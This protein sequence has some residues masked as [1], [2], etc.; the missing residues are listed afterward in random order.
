AVSY[1]KS[2]KVSAI[3]ITGKA[4]S[5]LAP[6]VPT[7]IES[8]L[9]AF[10]AAVWCGVMAPSRLPKQIAARL[11]TEVNEALKAADVRARLTAGAL[12]IVWCSGPYFADH[13]RAAV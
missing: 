10:D 5:P 7:F 6:D 11:N 3:A 8:G 12:E 9:P 2:D 1:L 13:P 4:R